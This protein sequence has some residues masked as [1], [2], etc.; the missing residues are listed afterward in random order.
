MVINEGILLSPKRNPVICDN[1][2]EQENI[3]LSEKSQVQNNNY[4]TTSLYVEC[5]SVQP[6]QVERIM[7][8]TSVWWE[9]GGG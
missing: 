7:I 3:I 6:L 4:R 2:D 5:K 9:W 8:F 1:T